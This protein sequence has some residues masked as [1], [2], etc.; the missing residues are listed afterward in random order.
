MIHKRHRLFTLIAMLFTASM[1]QSAHAEQ[2]L[3]MQFNTGQFT[4][5]LPAVEHADL[6]EQVVILRSQLIE[7]KQELTQ[8]VAD[9][10]LD[11][12]D[13]VIT[14]I[15]PGGL[16]YAGYKKARYEQAKNAL[17]SVN[18]DIEELSTDLVNLQAYSP[19]TVVARIP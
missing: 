4:I 12:A 15:M 13:A 14:I 5:Q 2:T 16:L 18:T 8:D 7:D 11:G 19:P 10:E 17:T 9:T 1:S 6:V 3:A